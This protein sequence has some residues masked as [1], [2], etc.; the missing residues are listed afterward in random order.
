MPTGADIIAQQ[1]HAAGCRHAFGMPGGEVLALLDALVRCGISFHLAKHEN[2]AGFM[3]EGVWHATGAPGILLATL[4]PGVANCA[5]VVAN[6]LQDRVPM[7]V[8]TGRVDP[9]EA[10]TYTHQV[11]DHQALMRPI[12]KASFAPAHGAVATVIAKALTIA[13]AG[14]PGPVHID[15]AIAVAEGDEPR[16]FP[17][18]AVAAAP[19]APAP[20]ADLENARAR[21]SAARRPLVIAGVDAVNQQSGEAIRQFC[22]R[23]G[24]PLL[25]SYKGKGLLDETHELALGGAGLSPKADQILLPL[26]RQADL[27]ILAGYDPIEMRINWRYPWDDRS[28]VVEC[29]ASHPVHFTHRADLTFIG[30]IAS[31][32]DALALPMPREPAWSDGSPQLTKLRLREAFA[33]QTAWG[34]AVI[35]ETLRELAPKNT[36]ATV[37]SGAHRILLSQIWRCSEPRTLLQSTA[38]CTMGCA[39]PLAIGYQLARSEDTVMAFMGDA[40]CEMVVGELA[41][42][43]DLGLPIIIVVLVDESLALIEMKQKAMQKP[44][45]GVRFGGTDFVA[46]AN[47]FGGH[48]VI[49]ENRADLS[50]AFATALGRR[51]RFT[52]IAARIAPDAYE[53]MI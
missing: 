6:A 8:L 48:G 1:L 29:A 47:A 26:L 19:M 44:R 35:F 37:D 15:M 33:P 41:T 46:V 7:I 43:R 30:D 42:A 13:S 4:G 18:A 2:A 36:V 50:A 51:D 38:L 34:P 28:Y 24:A 53:G 5:N 16:P 23:F 39:L 21:L 27:I 25:T 17:A 14:Q 32:L 40:G 12:T 3:A 45:V 20:G 22:K 52:L 10:E 31:C 49:V 11:F 9:A